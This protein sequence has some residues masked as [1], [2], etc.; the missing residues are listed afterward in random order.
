MESE[1]L[2]QFPNDLIIAKDGRV[3]MSGMNWETNKGA[4]WTCSEGSAQELIGS[5]RATNGITLSP[6]E[7]YLYLSEGAREGSP[8]VVNK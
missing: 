4:L 8:Q 5:S 7:K 3:Y 2:N 1:A 6:D